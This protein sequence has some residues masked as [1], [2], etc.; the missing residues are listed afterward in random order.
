[1]VRDPDGG[2]Y[3]RTRSDAGLQPQ[4]GSTA[5][6][7]HEKAFRRLGVSTRLVVLDNLREGVLSADIHDPRL[8]PLYRDVLAHYDVTALP[9]KVRD[10]DRKGTVESGVAHA[11]KTPRKGKTVRATGRGAGISQSLGRTPGRYPQ[12]W[13][14]QPAGGGPVRRREAIAASAA[15]GAISLLPVRTEP[16]ARMVA[17]NRRLC[18]ATRDAPMQVLVPT[19]LR[20]KHYP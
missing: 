3:R 1:M 6:E 20:S 13:P 19:S 8:N 17:L 9:C 4:I 14:D 10:P 18:E 2:K 12:P 5:A 7:L 11:Q 16:S 15:D